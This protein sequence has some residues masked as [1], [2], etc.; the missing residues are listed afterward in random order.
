MEEQLPVQR[1]FR[2]FWTAG[3]IMRR[4]CSVVSSVSRSR[5]PSAS[6]ASSSAAQRTLVRSST[7]AVAP[8]V[9]EAP[10]RSEPRRAAAAFTSSASGLSSAFLKRRR[11]MC[12]HS[13]ATASRSFALS[14]CL[15][16]NSLQVITH[17]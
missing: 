2:Y 9:P 1:L 5:V 16:A 3:C 6:R 11:P 10:G 13:F 14:A 7:P 15:S 17:L 4:F 8:A 12:A